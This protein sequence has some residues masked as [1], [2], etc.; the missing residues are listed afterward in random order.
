MITTLATRTL[1]A[2]LWL[3]LLQRLPLQSRLR[4]RRWPETLLLPLVLVLLLLQSGTR[5]ASDS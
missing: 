2:L 1:S 4:Q 5:E 3:L